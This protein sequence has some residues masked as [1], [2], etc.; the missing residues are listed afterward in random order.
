M[1]AFAVPA[2]VVLDLRESGKRKQHPL[3]HVERLVT[4]ARHVGPHAA[5][6]EYNLTAPK[7]LLICSS[8]F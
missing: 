5:A 7:E 2:S 4:K 1:E 6:M 3:E 8:S